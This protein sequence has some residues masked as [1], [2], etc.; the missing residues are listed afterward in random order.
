MEP[1]RASTCFQLPIIF[2]SIAAPSSMSGSRD[3]P[4]QI[5]VFLGGGSLARAVSSEP[6]D[7]DDIVRER[8]SS[9]AIA[10]PLFHQ[11]IKKPD[12]GVCQRRLR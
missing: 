2:A 3:S 10:T 5:T 4:R 1:C 9:R 6:R 12:F 11:M 7:L 8:A